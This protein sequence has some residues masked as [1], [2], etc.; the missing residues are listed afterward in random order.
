MSVKYFRRL[1]IIWRRRISKKKKRKR[2]S[3]GVEVFEADEILLPAKHHLDAARA[4]VDQTTA[5]SR[6]VTYIF[7]LSMKAGADQ[8]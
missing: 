8:A 7:S 2:S 4:V 6:V 5:S 1:K 3:R